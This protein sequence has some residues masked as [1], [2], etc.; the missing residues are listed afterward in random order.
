MLCRMPSLGGWDD[1][2]YLA[3]LTSLLDDGDLVLH[4]ELV[5]SALPP[6]EKRRALT[7]LDARGALP[8]AFSLGPALAHWPL[9]GLAALAGRTT[10]AELR[11]VLGLSALLLLVATFLA[12][13]ELL[14]QL[15]YPPG[16]AEVATL[17]A[18]L[19]SPLAL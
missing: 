8:N 2:F 6:A 12:C 5:S 1:T 18:V 16:R 7:T 17:I 19:G 11:P 13:F 10:A 9:A 4:D 14:R 15:N 3:Q